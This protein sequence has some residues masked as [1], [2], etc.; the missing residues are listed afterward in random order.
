[1]KKL[2]LILPIIT[3]INNSI[4]SQ[5]KPNQLRVEGRN[6]LDGNGQVVRLVGINHGHA[7][8]RGYLGSALQGI[9]SWGCNSV[10]I[11]LSNGYRWTKIPAN[12]VSSIINE[13]R[14]NG[15]K[16]IILE[17]HDTTG[18]G[19]QSGACNL[20]AAVNYW[21]EI[22]SVLV[23]Q[24]D[25]VIINIGNEPHGNTNYS[26]WKTDTINA[27]QSLRNNGFTHVLMVDAPNWGQDWTNT[28]RYNA[29][30]VLNSD[31]LRNVIFSVHMYEVY[32]NDSKVNTY[33]SYFYN[34]NLPLCVGEF[35]HWH[36]N[37]DV[38]EASIVNRAKQY[39]IHLFAWSWC[40]N[41][42]G[43]EYLDL[44]NNWNPN[45]PT[46]WGTFF[47]NN[48][49]SGLPQMYTLTININP[50]SGGSVSL[51]PSGGS[52]TAGTQVTLQAQP[53]SGYIFSGWS[54]DLSGTQNPAT[55][56]M[57][58]NKNITANFTQSS[59]GGTATYIL[60]VNIQPQNAGW[61]SMHPVGGVYTA[62]STVTLTAYSYSGYRFLNWSGDVSSTQNPLVIV[63]NSNLSLNANFVS[64]GIS[65]YTVTVIISPL[66]AGKVSLNPVGGVYQLNTQVEISASP[67]NGY[68][69]LNW[70][71]DISSNNPSVTI[72][73]DSNKIIYA[74]FTLEQSTQ[75]PSAEVSGSIVVLYP[76]TNPFN[77]NRDG[78]TKLKYYLNK[79]I[80]VRLKIY[81]IN[82][83]LIKITNYEYKQ[84]GENYF[85]FDAKD[86]D[87]FSLPTGIYLYQIESEN[88][89]SDFGK[90]FVIR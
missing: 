72:L 20:Q 17:V 56:T 40:G 35:G 68:R 60:N 1:M 80:P 64:D 73:V 66:N 82:L 63:L 21:I 36:N 79:A 47:K 29:S 51:N 14:N 58:S 59:G 43:Y 25:F 52:Y 74:N 9:R 83:N 18:Y 54:G 13:A 34:N 5:L 86:N 45:S 32:N 78:Y 76:T 55:I 23:N 88:E 61:I 65:T 53:N 8:Y 67:Y 22:K 87:G 75:P 57:N 50:Q 6:L 4:F 7:W 62:G 33:M 69:F 24:E 38:D 15:F 19:E 26:S 42:S 3:I 28:M 39:G 41:G 37:S 30:D 12:E 90:V 10:R 11:V 2:F 89:K 16:A 81:D 77:P 70:S 27:I 85:I 48:A 31:P 44:V 49:L 46:Q 71:G 84:A